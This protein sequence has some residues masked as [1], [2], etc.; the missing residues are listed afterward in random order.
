VKDTYHA[1]LLHLFFATFKLNRLA[2]KGS[3]IVDPTGGN[4]ASYSQRTTIHANAEY[5]QSR[6]R[7][8]RQDYSLADPSLLDSIDEFGDGINIQIF[9]VF[10]NFLLQQVENNIAVCQVLPKGDR[11]HRV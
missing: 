2:S 8:S 11:R 7:A 3:V 6:L 1:G 10:P 9:S 4:H 5:D